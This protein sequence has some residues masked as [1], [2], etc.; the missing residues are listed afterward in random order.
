M[1]REEYFRKE[2]D[3]LDDEGNP[4]GKKKVGPEQN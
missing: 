1:L 2:I 3:V 4:A